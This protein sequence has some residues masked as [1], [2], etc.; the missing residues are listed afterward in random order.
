[1]RGT[2]V[3]FVGDMSAGSTSEMRLRALSALGYEVAA[4]DY[5]MQSQGR[6]AQRAHRLSTKLRRPIDLRHINR[7]VLA[8]IGSFDILWSDK[9]LALRPRTLLEL[10]RRDPDALVV[11]YSTDDMLQR[12]NCSS[13]FEQSLP[14]TD[15]FLTTKSFNVRELESLGCP[16]VIFVNQGFDP[17]THRPPERPLK[18]VNDVG[19]VG[20]WEDGRAHLIIRLAESGIPVSVH[21]NGWAQTERRGIPALEFG[22][23]MMG[24]D[25]ATLIA[26]TRIN[27]GFLRKANRDLQ[28]TRSVE[29]PASGGFMLAERSSEHEQLFREGIEAEFFTGYGELEAKVR[30]YLEDEP[31]R[32]DIASAGRRRCVIDDYSYSGQLLRGLDLAGVRGQP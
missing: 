22:E 19:F 5:G 23:P 20:T 8:G 17:E 11:G 10:R 26:Q 29:I 15:L 25:Y 7:Q 21:G 31:A 3:L 1:M 2:R 4:I 18:F 12:N 13:F 6:N 24:R 32:R 9:A 30:K 14:L 16:R 28:T 27:L